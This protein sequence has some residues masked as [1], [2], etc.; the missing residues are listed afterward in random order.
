[1]T[2]EFLKAAKNLTDSERKKALE[3]ALDN[4]SETEAGIIRQVLGNK[5]KPSTEKQK[6]VY[7]NHILPALVE[8]CGAPGCSRFSLAG[9]IYCT[10]CAIEYGE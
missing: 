2:D 8:K 6:K 7:E 10:T 9:K 5:D 4:V 3:S 1:M